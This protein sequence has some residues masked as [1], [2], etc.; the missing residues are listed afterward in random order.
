MTNIRDEI[1]RYIQDTGEAHIEGRAGVAGVVF[2]H[3][4]RE[5]IPFNDLGL[6]RTY[7]F[8][9]LSDLPAVKSE[10][11]NENP[12]TLHPVIP[13]DRDGNWR[14]YAILDGNG[15]GYL[16]G[17]K[18][19]VAELVAMLGNFLATGLASEPIA[20]DDESL[21]VRWLSI[22]E[23]VAAA[24]GYD[25]AEYPLGEKTANRIRAAIRRGRIGGV[26]QDARG[27]YKFH[28]GRFRYWLTR[29]ER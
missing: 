16:V 7:G 11:T 23:A 12:W 27:R 5:F 21:G 19:Q 28:A 8:Y 15:F 4:E 13:A 1:I 14:P 29:D 22:A 9:R 24:N 25:P 10:T 2:H 17:E 18:W 26:A 20:D 6:N 3:D